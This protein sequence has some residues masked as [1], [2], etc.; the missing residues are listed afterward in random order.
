MAF[1][2]PANPP[3]ELSTRSRRG[4]QKLSRHSG[5]DSARQIENRPSINSNLGQQCLQE[6]TD[7]EVNWRSRTGRSQLH[8]AMPAGSLHLKICRKIDFGG[9]NTT[10]CPR[11]NKSQS[12]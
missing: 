3:L 7:F 5:V 10:A 4:C 12:E 11:G 8:I 2:Y 9:A 6:R 1:G